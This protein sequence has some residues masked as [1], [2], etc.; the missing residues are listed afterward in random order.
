MRTREPF[1]R[2]DMRA[3]EPFEPSSICEQVSH[4]AVP[5]HHLHSFVVYISFFSAG[6]PLFSPLRLTTPFDFEGLSRRSLLWVGWATSRLERAESRSGAS[7]SSPRRASI[8]SPRR[9]N[10]CRKQE[11]TFCR[12]EERAFRRQEERAFRRQEE[13]AFR[14][15]E[16]RSGAFAAPSECRKRTRLVRARANSFYLFGA[17]GQA[18]LVSWVGSGSFTNTVKVL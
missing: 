9:A 10:F 16:E 17:Q 7:I 15:Q 6:H 3:S 4:S 12:Q 2:R 18:W 8:S 11:R 5:G 14:R 13:R 1:N